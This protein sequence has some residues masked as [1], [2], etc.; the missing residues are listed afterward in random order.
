MYATELNHKRINVSFQQRRKHLAECLYHSDEV[1]AEYVGYDNVLHRI[2]INL[3]TL[4]GMHKVN[5]E[6]MT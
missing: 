3:F 2:C 6:A 4:T 5:I 1:K